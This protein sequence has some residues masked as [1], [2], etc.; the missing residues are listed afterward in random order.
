MINQV[1]STPIFYSPSMEDVEI[2]LK[3]AR[4]I[5]FHVINAITKDKD[6]YSSN[7]EALDEIIKDY[8]N[9]LVKRALTS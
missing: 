6:R 8:Q 9:Q 5:R 7:L 1:L 4:K 2:A 3:C